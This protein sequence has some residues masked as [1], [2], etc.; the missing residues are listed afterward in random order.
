MADGLSAAD[1]ALLDP[2][3][4]FA[5]RLTEDR[6]TLARLAGA[7]DAMG[8]ADEQTDCLAAIELV[9]HRLAGAAGTFGHAAVSS[10]ALDLEDQVIALRKGADNRSAVASGLA[11]L[12]GALDRALGSDQSD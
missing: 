9:A 7:L 1:L 5:L 3:G 10:A 6:T 4:T 2:D 11:M 8:P 12:V